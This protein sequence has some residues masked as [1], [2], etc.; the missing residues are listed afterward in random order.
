LSVW[1]RPA[2]IRSSRGTAMPR[3]RKAMH[4]QQD[5]ERSE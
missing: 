2:Y 3:F 5:E 4:R 1:G